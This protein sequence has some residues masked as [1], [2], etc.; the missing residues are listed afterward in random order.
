MKSQL[1]TI[2]LWY[3]PNFLGE[4]SLSQFLGSTNPRIPTGRSA[5][6]AEFVLRRGAHHGVATLDA[7]L[8]LRL[9]VLGICHTGWGPV[10]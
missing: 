9:G 1:I 3:I 4:I 6:G 8:R 2:L 5:Q 10:M 7:A